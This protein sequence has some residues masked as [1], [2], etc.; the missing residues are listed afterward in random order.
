MR[1]SAYRPIIIDFL[2]YAA[3]MRVY[4]YV[5]FCAIHDT[6]I[7]TDALMSVF[8]FMRHI[9]AATRRACHVDRLQQCRALRDAASLVHWLPRRRRYS[10]RLRCHA[11]FT[12]RLSKYRLLASKLFL[13]N[14]SAF[15][16]RSPRT[17]L[18]PLTGFTH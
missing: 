16:R 4:M 14:G 2:R 12:W 5:W 3:P 10:V 18:P 1:E 11:S 15:C 9:A 7:G 17:A 13:E 6:T 8:F